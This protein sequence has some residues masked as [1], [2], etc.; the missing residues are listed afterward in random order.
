MYAGI[1]WAKRKKLADDIHKFV[2]HTVRQQCWEIV[3]PNPVKI[4]FHIYLKDKRKRDVDNF[5]VKFIIDGL[6]KSGILLG[7]D[8]DH[9]YGI[10]IYGYYSNENKVII[11][12]EDVI[13][14]L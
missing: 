3:I 1:H 6:V 13:G 8:I 14:K 10:K 2:C 12:I 5:A 11:V 4:T 9:I 7:D